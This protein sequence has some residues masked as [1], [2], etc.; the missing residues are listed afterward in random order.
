MFARYLLV[1]SCLSLGAAAPRP[2]AADE[3]A[4]WA[5]ACKDWDD[6]DKPGPPFHIQG[7]SYYVGTCGIAAILVVSA[8]GHALIDTGTEAGAEVV[9]ANIR[10][11]G[12]NPAHIRVLLTSHEH[13]DHVGG[14]ATLQEA[15]G[16]PVHTSPAAVEV[17]RS[18][19]GAAD[20]PQ[21]GMHPAMRPVASIRPV[22]FGEPV[23]V[24]LEALALM[25][26][27]TPGHTP[28]ALTWQWESCGDGECRTIVYA[29]S[30]SP[31]SS[32]D[33]R[34]SDHPEYVQAY[35]A[36]L[37]RLAALECDILLT[38]HP[39]AS[40][41]RDKLLVGDIGGGTSCRDYVAAIGD[42]LDQRLAEEAGRE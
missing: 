19:H 14:L 18:G 9:M 32:D 40:G 11:L 12:F 10:A 28:G 23:R 4:P 30:L 42:R 38:P 24:G 16:A 22:T 21:H 15:S 41:M 33:Y 13:Y 31:V 37:V 3:R 2:T 5:E 34:F 26:V 27:E 7:N 25:P 8:H 20:D 29:D 35:R 6:W 39:S 17:L 1:L 36:G